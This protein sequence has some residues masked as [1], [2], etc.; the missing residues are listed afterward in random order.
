MQPIIST[1]QTHQRTRFPCVYYKRGD[2]SRSSMIVFS[3]L[4][5][6]ESS[7]CLCCER[8]WPISWCGCFMKQILL[9]RNSYS[10]ETRL[11]SKFG[12][13]A[14]TIR[15]MY[16]HTHT[17]ASKAS[18][19]MTHTKNIK[20]EDKHWETFH[21]NPLRGNGNVRPREFLRYC[22]SYSAHLRHYH[23]RS[24]WYAASGM[25]V[26]VCV[27][28]FL[29]MSGVCFRVWVGCLSVYLPKGCIFF[30][31]TPKHFIPKLKRRP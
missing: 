12:I 22:L 18:A 25:N 30:S 15:P 20:K 27:F 24:A 7:A 21:C 31:S 14:R 26:C 3:F 9:Q 5:F 1:I 19:T 16:T 29:Y 13:R 23:N 6:L 10:I 17:H 2:P 11:G 8:K 28:G 4:F